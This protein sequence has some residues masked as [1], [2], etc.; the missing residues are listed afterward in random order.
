MRGPIKKEHHH[1]IIES[2]EKKGLLQ[3][4]RL[5]QLHHSENKFQQNVKN[6]VVTERDALKSRLLELL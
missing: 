4:L 6:F 3:I 5:N 1:E 2:F